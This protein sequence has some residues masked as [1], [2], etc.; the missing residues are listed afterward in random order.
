MRTVLNQLNQR[1][2]PQT[3]QAHPDQVRNAAGGYVFQLDD[4]ARLDR[5]LILGVDAGT[6]YT[7][8]PKL[9][10]DNAKV[11]DR[12]LA[13]DPA[14]TVQLACDVSIMGRAANNDAA[15]FV[16]ARAMGH[17]DARLFA[18]IVLRNTARIG[19]HLFHFADMVQGQ[20]GWGRSLRRA[21]AG[22]YEAPNPDALA[23]QAV[24]YR[25]RDGWTHRDLLRLA[26]PKAPTDEH[27]VVYDFICGRLNAGLGTPG[28]PRIVEGYLK[29]QASS[30][31]QET[32]ELVREYQLP[33]ETLTTDHLASPKVWDALLHTPSALPL[34]ALVRN[35]GRMT[36]NGLL[37]PG[38]SAVREVGK[39]LGDWDAIVKARLHPVAVLN[40]LVAYRNGRGLKGKL[41]WTPV[42][43]VVDALDA[44]FYQA[45]GAVEPAGK[46]TLLALDV[47]SSMDWAACTGAAFT[48]R[49]GAAAMAMVTAATE[50]DWLAMAFST[51][52]VPVDISRR[53]RLDDLCNDLRRTPMG[54]TD[55]A[56]PMIWAA[57]NAVDVDTFIV[58]TDNETWHG[59]VHPHQALEHYRQQRGIPARLVVVGMTATESRMTGPDDGGSLDVVGFDTA[60]PNLISQFSAGRY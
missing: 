1:Q 52:F 14:R 59:T 17:P 6:Y 7:S 24:K 31:H 43:S 22:W 49:E 40:A 32:A 58:Y 47:S 33:W 18:E 57:N 38:A 9:A 13:A 54:G 20:R 16:L 44:A 4:W 53:R 23:Y 26:H 25:Q 12:C 5:F 39:R 55:C 50:P 36:A 51:R 29:A 19:T 2:T 42:G 30:D 35:L 15:L 60:A 48:A 37:A 11:V 34:G 10:A 45:F 3:E 41:T 46:R 27:R 21:V 56:L 8:P 28:L